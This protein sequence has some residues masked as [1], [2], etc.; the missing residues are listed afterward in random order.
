MAAPS[1]PSRQELEAQLIA[2]AWQDEAFKRELLSDPRAAIARV[3]GS[4]LPPGLEVKVVEETPNTVYV[5]IPL[6]TTELSDEQLE[7]AAGGQGN[8]SCQLPEGW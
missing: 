5:V 2:R 1:T 7:A 6:N 4:S 8:C 3:T